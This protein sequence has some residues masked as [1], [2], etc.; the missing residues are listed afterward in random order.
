MP[1]NTTSLTTRPGQ[2]R[3]VIADDE[4]GPL[5]T[6]GL[7][8]VVADPGAQAYQ[9]AGLQAQLSAQGQV[10]GGVGSAGAHNEG[11]PGRGVLGALLVG[12]GGGVGGE[13]RAVGA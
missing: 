11:G 3:F 8:T 4:I 10:V 1:E 13:G 12:E 5:L 6:V 9:A 2:E 7:G